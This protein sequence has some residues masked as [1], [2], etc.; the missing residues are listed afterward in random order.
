MHRIK[1]FY[2]VPS[3]A[4]AH[5]CDAL[6]RYAPAD[7]AVTTERGNLGQFSDDPQDLYMQ[8]CYSHTQRLRQ[9][10]LQQKQRAVIV[11][12]CNTGW[13]SE[14]PREGRYHYDDMRMAAD[15]IIFNS[16]AAWG[17]AGKPPQTS[18]ISNGVD[19]EI[20]FDHVPPAKRT[21]RVL[22][23]GSHYHTEPHRDLKGYHSHLL[24]LQERL[25]ARGIACDFRRIDSTATVTNNGNTH[26]KRRELADWYN[27]G[28][29]Y[30]VASQSEGT[31]NPAL[32]AAA[33]GC[34]VVSTLVG[35][36]PELIA[37][38][39]NGL[40]VDRQ[41]DALE[42]AVVEAVERY[43]QWGPAMLESIEPWAWSV[44]ARLYYDLF[45]RLLEA[46]HVAR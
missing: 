33:C 9:H 6:R 15:W 30:V 5:R 28:T 41:V 26:Y 19:R 39:M 29:V 2:D 22:W 42:A 24:P 21:P 40:L 25:E 4:Y 16:R 13:A 11:T 43:T 36:M 3:W 46:N 10:L 34:T 35:N 20:F 1:L 44:R 23:L 7:F 12:G 38:G 14:G 27:T 32:E 8:L 45:R 17:R 37:H 31:P 18:W